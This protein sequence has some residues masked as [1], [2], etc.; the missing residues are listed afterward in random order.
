MR[1]DVPR[2]RRT[3]R[4]AAAVASVTA[5]LLT[6]TSWA[7]FA[8]VKGVEGNLAVDTSLGRQLV[9]AS[10]APSSSSSEPNTP[11]NILVVGTDTRT[12]QG[13]AYGTTVDSSGYG[14]SDTAFLLHISADRKSAFAV[15]IPRDSWVVRPGCRADGTTDGTLTPPGRFNTAFAVGG[16]NCVIAVVKYLTGVPVNHFVEVNFLGFEAIVNALGGVDIC[17]THA[18]S[19]PVRRTSTGFVGSGLEL[20][21]GNVHVNGTQALALVRARHIGD[22]SDLSRIDRQHQF[23]SA[24]IRQA[25]SAGLITDPVKLYDV[26]S[27]VAQSLTVDAGLTG[28]A[29]QEFLLSLQGLKPSAIRFYTVPNVGRSDHA[30]VEWVRPAAQLMWAAMIKDTAYPAKSKATASSSAGTTSTKSASP[31]STDGSSPST[32]SDATCIS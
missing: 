22:G 30:T 25:T 27:K 8:A 24:V 1:S 5:L 23:M 28:D 20:P 26:L 4:I 19:D 13:R 18:I 2:H 32:A 7:G 12:G 16:R 17:T 6:A 31:A 29:L 10:A 14:H 11:E 3:L 15:S 21:K 9:A